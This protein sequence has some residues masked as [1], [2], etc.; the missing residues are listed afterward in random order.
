MEIFMIGAWTIW[1]ERNDV[2]FNRRPPSV[3]L[4]KATFKAEVRE[5]F[6]R[7]K[8]ELHQPIDSWLNAL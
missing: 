8:K 6:I 1:K 3:A 5:H 2:I 7:F 4:W